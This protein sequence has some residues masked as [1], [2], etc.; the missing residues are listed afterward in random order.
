MAEKTVGVQ[1]RTYERMD[2]ARAPGQ[3]FDGFIRQMMNEREEEGE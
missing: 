3:S 1:K 2:E